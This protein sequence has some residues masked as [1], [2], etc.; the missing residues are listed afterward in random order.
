ME[1]VTSKVPV[2]WVFHVQGAG[3]NPIGSVLSGD[4]IVQEV[5]LF[6]GRVLYSGSVLNSLSRG[7]HQIMSTE[8][9]VGLALLCWGW[10]RGRIRWSQ[11]W[12]R[13]RWAGPRARSAG[14]DPGPDLPG[15]DPPGRTRG[16]IRQGRTCWGWSRW[17]RIRG[18]GPGAGSVGLDPGPD[19]PE[20]DP[21]PDPWGQTQGR[22]RIR[23]SRIRRGWTWIRRG[24]TRGRIAG[25]EQ[26][27]I[28]ASNFFNNGPIL[29]NFISFESS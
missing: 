4:N 9:I 12:G 10:T 17:G 8:C 22:G 29:I 2:Q 14:P 26:D 15:L 7:S 3:P 20:P 1:S 25:Q 5:I 27:Y 19:L 28:F 24:W 16:W 11:T 21:G 23:L 13:I 6:W 18:A